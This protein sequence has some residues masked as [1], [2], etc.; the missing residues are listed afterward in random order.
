MSSPILVTG[1]T[2]RLGVHLVERLL[3]AGR[4]VRVLSRGNH[5]VGHRGDARVESVTA[6]LATGDGVEAGV[7]GIE[8]VVH[9]AGTSKGDDV[10]TRHIVDAAARAGVRHL[11]YI[12]V[13]GA[14]RIPM[15]SGLDRMMFGY[16]GSKA[17]SERIIAESTVPWTTLRAT[18]FHDLML[19][20]AQKIARLPVIPVPTG[21][22]CQPIEADEVAIRLRD[23]AL[24][25]PL[26]LVADVAGPKV[27]NMADL[28][29]AYLRA[30]DLHR[31]LL[32][33]WLPGKAAHA[34]RNGATL[35]PRAVG[36]LTWEAFL[37]E[38]VQPRRGRP[39]RRAAGHGTAATVR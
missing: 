27:Y 39:A 1:G 9:C 7:A 14:D 29:R 32:P 23:L 18:Q 4:P 2:G 17:A 25:P 20:M 12:S 10:Q 34:V 11:V 24:G 8:T 3:A 30:A 33:I 36:R 22:P 13:V 15:A 37:A 35:S 31:M 28:M 26:G 6:D 16:F 38:R 19:D 5:D 21:T